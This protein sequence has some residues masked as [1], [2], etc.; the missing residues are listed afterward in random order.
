MSSRVFL[1]SDTSIPST[2]ESFKKCLTT[3]RAWDWACCR[4]CA[5]SHGI[6]TCENKKGITGWDSKG[7]ASWSLVLI[8]ISLPEGFAG[9]HYSTGWNKPRELITS[10]VQKPSSVNVMSDTSVKKKR[11]KQCLSSLS[12]PTLWMRSTNKWPYQPDARSKKHRHWIPISIFGMQDAQVTTDVQRA[13]L[14]VSI[15]VKTRKDPIRYRGT[16]RTQDAEPYYQ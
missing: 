8:I 10:V 11:K 5:L 12:S 14:E 1:G 9:I 7:D 4:A 13:M 15:L 16:V 6:C 2:L 3:W